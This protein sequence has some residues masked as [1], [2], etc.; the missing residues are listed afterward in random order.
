METVR[1]FA[2]SRD[3]ISVATPVGSLHSELTGFHSATLLEPQS[4]NA[5]ELHHQW[6]ARYG[7]LNDYCMPAWGGRWKPCAMRGRCEVCRPSSKALVNV[8]ERPAGSSDARRHTRRVRC[9]CPELQGK[10]QP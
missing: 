8:P 1:T 5:L 4:N 9:A 2:S 3:V 10:G 7:Q 6:L